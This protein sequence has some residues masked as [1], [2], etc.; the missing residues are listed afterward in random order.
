M[1]QNVSAE[2][3]RRV[4]ADKTLAEIVADSADGNSKIPLIGTDTHL[5]GYLSTAQRKEL[6]AKLLEGRLGL[7]DPQGN[8]S[9]VTSLNRVQAAYLYA[10]L[11]SATPTEAMDLLG[12]WLTR[13]PVDRSDY[14][15]PTLGRH[16]RTED[17]YL[18]TM[19]VDQIPAHYQIVRDEYLVSE[20]GGCNLSVATLIGYAEL[21]KGRVNEW[22]AQLD[23]RIAATQGDAKATWLIA[24]GV[25]A[26]IRRCPANRHITSHEDYQASEASLAEASEVATTANVKS[27]A[28]RERVVRAM[29]NR[30]TQLASQLAA[31]T[32]VPRIV[33][34]VAQQLEAEQTRRRESKISAANN[35]LKVMRQRLEAAESRSDTAQ[36]AR[37]QQLV[38]SAEQAISAASQVEED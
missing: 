11:R 16:S 1:I 24:R 14:P 19:L 35:R 38:D 21:F 31:Q 5:L 27:R 13:Y 33:D 7:D 17:R 30:Q 22:I 26:E 29:A 9:V 2:L 18:A 6:V 37:Y 3:W 34:E 20:N 8:T 10:A 36:V 12:T 23:Q 15:M 28:Y 25:A 4:T 32:G